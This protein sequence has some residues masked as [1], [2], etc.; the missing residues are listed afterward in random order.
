MPPPGSGVAIVPV[1]VPARDALLQQAAETYI[2]GL[3]PNTQ[4]AYQSRLDAFLIW[5]QDQKNGPLVVHLKQY[6]A[7]LQ[8]EKGLSARSVQVPLMTYYTNQV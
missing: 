8:H 3:A 4:R 1:D 6:V 5:R 7:H 2:A